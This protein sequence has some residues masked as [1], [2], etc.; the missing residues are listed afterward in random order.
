MTELNDSYT[1]RDIDGMKKVLAEWQ[2]SPEAVSGVGP[3]V[4]L[5]RIIRAISQ[6]RRRIAE[7]DK[8]LPDILTSDMYSLM[9]AVCEADLQGRDMLSEM[10][11]DLEDRITQA[12]YRL[13]S[14]K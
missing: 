5:I 9:V 11:R 12:Q 7:L 3:A 14:L 4:E 1:K 8:A 2:E 10:S 13:A 6:V